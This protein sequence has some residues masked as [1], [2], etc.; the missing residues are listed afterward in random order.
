MKNTGK[1]DFL[2]FSDHEIEKMK[3]CFNNLDEDGSGAIGIDELEG[4]LIGLGF[5]NTREEI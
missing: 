1:A 5:Y 2:D 3:E 4:P